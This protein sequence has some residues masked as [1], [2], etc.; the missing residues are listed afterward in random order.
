MSTEP[1]I[2]AA[3]IQSVIGAAIA[4]LVAFGVTVTEQQAAAIIGLWATAGPI[5][6]AIATRRKVTPA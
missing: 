5:I 3:A 4:L 2:T 6:F 1:V